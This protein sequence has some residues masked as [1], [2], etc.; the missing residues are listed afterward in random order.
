MGITYFSHSYTLP[1]GTLQDGFTILGH[2]I[3]YPT[4]SSFLLTKTESK[5]HIKTVDSIVQN[6][7]VIIE[8]EAKESKPKISTPNNTIKKKFVPKI[9]NLSKIDTSKIER[10]SYPTNKAEFISHLKKQLTASKSR[11]IHYGDSQIEG[12]RMS[13]YIRNKLQNLY[14][15]TG[16]GFTPVAQVYE[17][18]SAVVTVSENWTRHATFDR[19]K[20]RFAHKK[21]GA[22]TSLSRFTPQYDSINADTLQLKKASITVKPSTMTYLNMRDYT[23]IGFHY[24]NTLHPVA[25]KVFADGTLIKEGQL[26]SDGNYHNFNIKLAETPSDLKFELEGKISPDVYGLTLDGNEGISLDNVAMRGSAGTVFAG[27]DSQNFS[28]MYSELNPNVVIFQYGGNSMPYVKDSLEVEQYAGYLKNHINWV[29]RKTKDASIIFIGPTDMTTTENGQLRTYPLLP[30]LNTTLRSMCN[31][32]NIAY[33]STFDAM[34]GENS[35]E[36]W[37][38]QKLAASDYTHFSLSG[39]RII[40]ELFFLSL[41]MDLTDN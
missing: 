28:Q 9:P 10:I 21:Y 26:I 34:G 23:N 13:S 16:P 32:N 15:G 17:N 20:K 11:I 38:N 22:Y 25:I 31:T 12:D 36:H 1:N 33:W 6:I 30:Y 2:T 5:D 40:S 19:S 35:M 8:P 4:T 29:R 39:T 7:E 14:G 3:K 41:Y 37:V 27:L 18:I 24:G